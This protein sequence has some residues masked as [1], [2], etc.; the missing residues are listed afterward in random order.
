MIE[1]L[2][3][4]LAIT[5]LGFIIVGGIAFVLIAIEDSNNENIPD[6]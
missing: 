1:F 4:L 3:I 5:I 6:D 2:K